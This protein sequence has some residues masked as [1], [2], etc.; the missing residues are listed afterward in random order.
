M[1]CL[2]NSGLPLSAINICRLAN[3]PRSASRFIVRD[4][5]TAGELGV[6]DAQTARPACNGS[7]CR[8]RTDLVGSSERLNA[9]FVKMKRLMSYGED[10]NDNAK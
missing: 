2:A 5:S 7:G 3:R 10:R 1:Q 4:R 8:R 9:K 6:G